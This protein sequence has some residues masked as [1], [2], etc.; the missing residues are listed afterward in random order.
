MSLEDK[1]TQ[2]AA[3]NEQPRHQCVYCERSY[4]Q[5]SHLTYHVKSDHQSLVKKSNYRNFQCRV[6]RQGRKKHLLLLCEQRSNVFFCNFRVC[7]FVRAARAHAYSRK[8]VFDEK[9]RRGSFSLATVGNRL[10]RGVGRRGGSGEEGKAEKEEAGGRRHCCLCRTPFRPPKKRGV[11]N[12]TRLKSKKK[13]SVQMRRRRQKTSFF[14][15]QFF[16]G[17]R[18]IILLHFKHRCRCEALRSAKCT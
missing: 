3:P 12:T 9:R 4:K 2:T 16:F 15:L 10:C 14:C 6:C 17:K 13:C 18:L 1:C 11:V 7:H 5:K 8:G